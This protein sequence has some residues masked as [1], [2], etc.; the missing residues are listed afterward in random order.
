MKSERTTL[1]P[2]AAPDA[3]ELLTVF[4]DPGV[5]RY[6]LD[7]SLVSAE[8]VRDEI[9]SSDARFASSGTGLWSIR[10]T[11]APSI[12]GFAGCRDF[13]DP[14][15]LQLIYGLLPG[16]WGR[17]LATEVAARV[18]DHAFRELGFSQ[19]SAAI[20]VPNEASARVL[21]RLGMKMK[22]TTDEG[23]YGTAFYVLDRLSWAA[24]IETGGAR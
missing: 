22:E 6:L 4:R 3:D 12:I 14:P 9:G 16:L 19:V 10:L 7:D 13:F 21:E 11:G 5:R 2:F 8:W 15:Q 1:R 20:D 23:S 18:C 24:R 17:G